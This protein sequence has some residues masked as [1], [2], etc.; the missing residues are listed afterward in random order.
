MAGVA[1]AYALLLIGGPLGWHRLYCG[2]A[3]EAVLYGHTFGYCGIGWLLDFLRLPR[4]VAQIGLPTTDRSFSIFAVVRQ[5]FIAY[6]YAAIAGWMFLY[7]VHDARDIDDVWMRLGVFA[8]QA[9]A[10]GAGVTLCGL[11]SGAQ[12]SFVVAAALAM[13]FLVGAH[14]AS[15]EASS[16]AVA[17]AGACMGALLTA[18]RR[19]RAA[20][21]V[22]RENTD[23]AAEAATRTP[24]PARGICRNT[25]R[26]A[27]VSLV[28]GLFWCTLLS[29]AIMHTDV[30]VNTE[31]RWDKEGLR[32]TKLGPYAWEHRAELLRDGRALLE[33]IRR[34][35]KVH[36]WSGVARDVTAEIAKR[37]E[38]DHAVLGVPRDADAA[39]VRAA[40]RRLARELHPDRL[41]ADLSSDERAARIA[42]FRRVVAAYEA[43]T[44]KKSVGGGGG[45]RGRDPPHADGD[46]L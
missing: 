10:A 7:T 15:A 14:T 17:A 3:A 43:L 37:R 32:T 28:Q 6:L 13:A 36:G 40:Y 2:Q 12:P 11:A 9:A 26:F 46:D 33:E 41:P 45:R 30:A 8:A 23:A 44:A 4:A 22:R 31:G 20:E 38:S 42:R 39:A 24:A 19:A 18:V 34:H 27:A 25:C 16:A 21:R 35:I 1:A 29:G 5:F